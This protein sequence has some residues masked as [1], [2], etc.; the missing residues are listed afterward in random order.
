MFVW[1]LCEF[2]PQ[3]PHSILLI[4]KETER[5]G[6]MDKLERVKYF[7]CILIQHLTKKIKNLKKRHLNR[8]EDASSFG[9]QWWKLIQ[10]NTEDYLKKKKKKSV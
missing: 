10:T 8:L 1:I 2:S 9:K 5:E 7:K 4:M 6:F 3:A